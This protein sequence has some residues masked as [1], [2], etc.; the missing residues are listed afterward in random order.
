LTS[1]KGVLREAAIALLF[2]AFAS[3]ATRP[4]VLHPVSLT[5]AGYDTETHTWTLHW[6]VTHF[7]DPGKIFE[8]NLYYPH[9]H[10]VLFTEIDLGTAVLLLPF[11][12]VSEDPVFLYNLGSVLA[13]AFAGWS[14]A[15]L[16]R[17]LS[18]SVW[19]SLG[20]GIL[21]AFGSNQMRHLHH[22][23]LITIGWIPLFLLGLHELIE[24]PRLGLVLTAGVSLALTVQSNGY[25]AVACA[26]LFV[27]F[28]V[29]SGRR[30]DRTRL[31]ALFGV[32]LLAVLLSAPYLSAFLSL[33]SAQHLHRG[34]GWSE[35]M[36]FHPTSDLGNSGYL[37]GA[38]LGRVGECL[39]PGLLSLGL[40]AWALRRRAPQAGFYAL[41]IATLLLLSLGPSLA[42][43]SLSLPLP[44]RLLVTV[45]PF[46][47]MRHPS[48]FAGLAC[49]LLAVLAGLGFATLRPRPGLGIA[50][51][52]LAM[53]EVS[54]PP[55]PVRGVS[56]GV[57]P[58]FEAL[59][60]LPEGP[61]LEI[62]VFSDEVLLCAARTD[63]D[64]LNGQDSSFFPKDTW[65]LDDFIQKEWLSTPL[66]V[67][68]RSNSSFLFDNYSFRYL[69]F[70]RG[71]MSMPGFG[72]LSR[73][74]ETSPLLRRV[75]QSRDGDRIYEVNGWHPR[76]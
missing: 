29:V 46:D 67:V 61:A 25:Y 53:V 76:D 34:V 5:F 21:A 8:G 1:A 54:A 38:I 31:V 49:F 11:R 27:L 60:A 19:A 62:P 20:A 51:V 3:F 75:A 70:P 45:P 22:L 2:L 59:S 56:S 64:F 12:L 50:F 72:P 71:R 7:F 10:A 23:D 58:V 14:T 24:E 48:T 74:L 30:L 35:H 39:F 33:R 41:A 52:V 16:V 73:A 28:V 55:H 26:L 9:R 57:P 15:F 66:E 4:L 32:G 63:R 18:G 37:Y 13:L 68:D 43:G 6:L 69:V 47:A 17:H 65:Q 40:G 42:L 44:Y 36:A